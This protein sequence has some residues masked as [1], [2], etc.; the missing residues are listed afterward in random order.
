LS[1]TEETRREAYYESRGDAEKRRRTVYQTLKR[2]GPCTVDD[3]V[4]ALMRD[5]TLK[6]FDRGYVAPRVT[7]LKQDGLIV[8]DGTAK[9]WRSNKTVTVFCVADVLGIK[10]AAPGGNDTESG[11]RENKS[12][13]NLPQEGGDVNGKKS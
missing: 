6:A 11:H 4:A 1:I 13:A 8:S 9:S 2:C 12:T 3:I 5:G 10:K 7:E